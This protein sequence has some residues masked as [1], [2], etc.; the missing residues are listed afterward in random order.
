MAII[1]IFTVAAPYGGGEQTRKPKKYPRSTHASGLIRRQGRLR[2][3]CQLL[4]HLP[5]NVPRDQRRRN[6][7]YSR[8]GGK[9][10]T[11]SID[12]SSPMSSPQK[13]SRARSTAASRSATGSAL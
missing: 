13:S 1:E 10:R 12:T 2:R 5:S 4:R 9:I 11:A 8:T 3:A 7:L 6:P